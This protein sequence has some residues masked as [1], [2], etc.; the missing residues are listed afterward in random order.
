MADV[1]ELSPLH[2]ARPQRQT[3]RGPLQGLD[4][5]H[6]ISADHAFPSRSTPWRLSVRG[7][8]VDDPLIAVFGWLVGGR[9][10]PIP[11]QVW[12]EIDFF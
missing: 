12:F 4:A 1:L 10:Q 8:H 6:L 3:R 9:C 7:A 2:V 11:N 5:S